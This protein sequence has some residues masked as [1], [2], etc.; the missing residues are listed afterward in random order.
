MRPIIYDDAPL[1]PPPSRIRHP[2]SLSEFAAGAQSEAA[3]SELQYRLQRQQLDAFHH[4]FWFD[5]RF[6][7]LVFRVGMNMAM[8]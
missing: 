5:V 8:F 3:V 7:R 1:P 2:Y 6:I 4:N